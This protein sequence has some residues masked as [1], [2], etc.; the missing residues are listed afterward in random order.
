[1]NNTNDELIEIYGK[2][3][4]E[5]WNN[6]LKF[7]CADRYQYNRGEYADVFVYRHDFTTQ[8]EL[9]SFFEYIDVKLE[10][11][12]EKEI[13]KNEKWKFSTAYENLLNPKSCKINMERVYIEIVGI[14]HPHNRKFVSVEV[15]DLKSYQTLSEEAFLS[16]RKIELL[17]SK[18]ARK[19]NF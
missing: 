11:V 6:G 13:N 3:Q 4:I 15:S 1:M 17:L 10:Y 8:Q 18:H 2:A 19:P 7:F 14:G 5:H 12:S 9:H 16:C